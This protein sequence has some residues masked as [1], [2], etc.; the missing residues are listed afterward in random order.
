MSSQKIAVLIGSLRKKSFNRKM[1]NA[2]TTLAPPTLNLEIIEIGGLSI[3][4]PDLDEAPPAAWI[5]FRDKIKTFDGGCKPKPPKFP[6][7]HFGVVFH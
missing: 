4:N 3:Y 7:A 2:L 5:E 1:A 6:A